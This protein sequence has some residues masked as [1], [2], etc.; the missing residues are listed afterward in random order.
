MEKIDYINEVIT[1]IMWF[2][3][4]TFTLFLPFWQFLSYDIHCDK[5]KD[6]CTIKEHLTKITVKKIKISN[7]KQLTF[8]YI[9]IPHRLTYYGDD[10]P[11][12]YTILENK[13]YSYTF[14]RGLLADGKED[15]NIEKFNNFINSKNEIFLNYTNTNSEFKNIGKLIL[16]AMFLISLIIPICFFKQMYIKTKISKRRNIIII[17]VFLILVILSFL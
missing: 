10:D 8:G 11:I 2:M 15:K 4:I 6:I 13:D 7:T 5:I 16:L 17:T 9:Y 14:V 12:Y 1:Y 3:I